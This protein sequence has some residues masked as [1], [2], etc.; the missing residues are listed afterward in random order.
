[1]QDRL[2]PGQNP[3]KNG[4]NVG[5]GMP[6]SIVDIITISLVVGFFNGLSNFVVFIGGGEEALTGKTKLQ[7]AI[8]SATLCVE[9][10]FR[11]PH[12]IDATC[13]RSCVCAM[14]W[15]FYAID[16]TLS[17]WPRRLSMT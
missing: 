5:F 9:I 14:A 1:M 7:A 3:N 2:R 10:K 11:A 6:G 15:R 16:A 8:L 4:N 13:F 17:P 12:A